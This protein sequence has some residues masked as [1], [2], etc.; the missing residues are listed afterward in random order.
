MSLNMEQTLMTGM[1][2]EAWELC[3]GAQVKVCDPS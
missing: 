2:E 3:P 1:E